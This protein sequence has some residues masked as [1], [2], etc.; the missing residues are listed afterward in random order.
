MIYTFNI[1]GMNY[2]FVIPINLCTMGF[3]SIFDFVG[4]MVLIIIKSL[5]V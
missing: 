3:V 4:L 1:I 2:N 5:G